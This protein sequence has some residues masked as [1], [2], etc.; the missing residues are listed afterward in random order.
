MRGVK[1]LFIHNTFQLSSQRETNKQKNL[2]LIFWRQRISRQG[3]RFPNINSMQCL[4]LA[5]ITHQTRRTG[6]L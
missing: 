6:K 3:N 1:P 2:I 4:L 5:I